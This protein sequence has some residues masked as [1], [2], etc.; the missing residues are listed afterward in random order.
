MKKII[1]CA[2][3]S[4]FCFK[5]ANA[6]QLEPFKDGDRVVF[7]GNSITHA[8]FYESYVWLYYMTHFP[9]RKVQ[10]LNGGSGG[11]V[12]G[13]MYARF[14]DDILKMNPNIV[15]LTFGM[16]DSG[17]AEFWQDD[18]EKTAKQR[19]AKSAHDFKLMQ[20]KLMSYPDIK[21]AIM[22]TSPFDETVK[23]DANNF[24][25]KSKTIEEIVA[26]QEKGAAKNNWPYID[27]YHPML[28]ITQR[29][30]QS[31]SAYTI[32]GPD[33]IHPGKPGHLVMASI[34]L[35]S[36]GLAGKPVADIAINA[37]AASIDKAENAKVYLLN[38]KKDQV[39]FQYEAQS[40]P[41]PIDST[42][43]AWGNP[44]QL[45]DALKVYPFVKEFNQEILKVDNLNAG[46]YK[47]LIDGNEIAQFT[48][49]DFTKGINMANYG[50][51]PQYKQ[52]KNVMFLNEQRA[53]IEGKLREY[54]WVQSNFFRDK[55]MLYEDSQQAFD[56]ASS[57]DNIFVTS[58][59]GIYRTARFPE[60]RKMWEDN[61]KILVDKIYEIN[62]P[63]TH[64]IEII[65]V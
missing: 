18:A 12:V 30:Q 33:R 8:G 50:N 21:P 7:L 65:K 44:Q 43:G 28:E 51:T 24:I 5:A 61:L 3:L 41:Y 58:K 27:L 9:E 47:L 6:Q 64:R 11:D 4:I 52:A 2:L 42:S 22:S 59:M 53:E 23:I 39:S 19:I 63:K 57:T 37:D 29:E 17:Y 45:G 31:D 14:E 60:I 49:A 32:T 16:N 35:K 15:V 26:F 25:G 10:I 13:Q 1:L 34:I 40:L 46:N 48:A 38:A 36:Q 20:E 54:E 55:G 62:K 56:A